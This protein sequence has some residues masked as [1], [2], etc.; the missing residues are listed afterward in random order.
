MHRRD[1]TSYEVGFFLQDVFNVLFVPRVVVA[2]IPGFVRVLWV[3]LREEKQWKLK[4]PSY[5][6]NTGTSSPEEQIQ[7]GKPSSTGFS[8]LAV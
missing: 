4:I 8:Y 6:A 3:L 1:F 5:Y 7:I 2:A